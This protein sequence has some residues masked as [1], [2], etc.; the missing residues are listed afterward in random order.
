M[1][2]SPRVVVTASSAARRRAVA[3]ALGDAMDT[4]S[5]DIGDLDATALAGADCLVVADEAADTGGVA[6]STNGGPPTIA[7]VD[8]DPASVACEAD[9]F[10]RDRGESAI[11]RLRDEIRWRVRDGTRRADAETA[12]VES[13]AKIER[14]H[15]VAAK[16]VA[17]DSERGVYDVAVRAAEEILDLD[18]VGIDV[19]EDGFFV[20]Q[21]VSDEMRSAGYG[22][23][24]VDQGIA[25]ETYQSGSSIVVADIHERA[26]VDP[27]GAYRS[28][29]SVPVGDF[30]LLQAGSTEIGAF[31]D[32][33]REL[34][35]LLATHVA[36][37]VERLRAED[38]LR[39]ER[40][41]LAALFENVPDPVVCFAYS[42]GSLRVVDANGQFERCFGWSADE[43]RGGDIDEFIVPEGFEAEA[44]ELN[45]K[46]LAGESHIATTKR[47]TTEGVRDFLLHV[48]PFALGERSWQGYAIYTDITDQQQRQRELERQNERLDAFASIV[49]HDLRNPLSIAQGYL[50]LAEETHD[51]AH[52]E[53]VRFAHERMNTL[54]DDLLTLARQ[55][56]VVGEC[57]P[58]SLEDVVKRAWA[59]VQTGSA[60]LTV[61]EDTTVTADRARLLEL[62]ENLFRNSVEHGSGSPARDRPGGSGD[63]A[64]EHCPEERSL[65][66]RVGPL[67]S[68]FFVEDDGCG[69]PEAEREA[70]LEFG[71]TTSEQGTGFGLTI[72]Q[73]IAEAHGWTFDVTESDSGGVR[74]EFTERQKAVDADPV[75]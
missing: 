32:R 36:E 9:G 18:I 52:F 33:D 37:T 19:L 42:D 70:V 48:V 26:D 54:V 27:A 23:I 67:E 38:E 41:R 63:T 29:L 22:R 12:L 65:S 46:L 49:S 62:L 66:I 25:G 14:L 45:E 10:V 71:F 72:V 75:A 11:E 17:C 53:E 39:R 55:G 58:V 13:H 28:I 61:T 74:F 64:V 35:E 4:E 34:A 24:P 57:E 8:A 68:G 40:D 21:V 16:M 51:S 6:S 60:T 3:A 7:F 44:T 30:G 69:I 1:T 73:E 43:I 50:D 59:S 2:V 56:D 5:V 31:D 47:L 20:P 15:E